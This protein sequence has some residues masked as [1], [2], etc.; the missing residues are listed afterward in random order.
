MRL[1]IV[2]VI[3]ATLS[4]CQATGIDYEEFRR[5]HLAGVPDPD[6]CVDTEVG[7]LNTRDKYVVL[8]K[9]KICL[10]IEATAP[11]SVSHFEGL[12]HKAYQ[13]VSDYFQ[14]TSPR[15]ITIV[16]RKEAPEKYPRALPPRGRIMIPLHA[17]TRHA[18][19]GLVRDDGIVVHEITH[20]LLGLAGPVLLKT[21]TNIYGRTR[22]INHTFGG[23]GLLTEGIAQLLQLEL[24]MNRNAGLKDFD[25]HQKVKR[26]GLNKMEEGHLKDLHYKFDLFSSGSIS[27]DKKKVRGHYLVSAS[28]AKYLIDTYGLDNFMRLYRG[29]DYQLTLG[30]SIGELQ[31]DWLE[32]LEEYRPDAVTS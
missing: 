13:K 32:F 25:F 20:A 14:L 18:P 3:L 29:G 7:S 11:L 30:R 1:A 21:D 17:L 12:V 9:D 19:D 26:D 28:F 4:G 23:S 15:V 22:Y 8:V 5:E 31:A 6:F 10:L 27:E 24:S 2:G 16:V